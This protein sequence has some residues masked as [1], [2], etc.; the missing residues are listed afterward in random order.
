MRPMSDVRAVFA[1]RAEGHSRAAI[2]RLTGVSR[3]QVRFWLELGPEAVAASPMRAGGRTSAHAH[4]E[5]ELVTFVNGPAYAYLFGQYLGDGCLS[6]GPREVFRL[7]I[8]TCDAY[9]HLR[10][11]CERAIRVVMPGRVVGRVHRAGCTDVS[12]YSR[13]WPCLLP[14]HGA[15]RKH[16]RP[17]QLESW[18]QRLVLDSHPERFLR[19]LLHSDGCRV[20]N[21]VPHHLKLGVKEYSYPR[22]FFRNESEDILG[23]FEDACDRLGI[24]WRR[25]NWKTISVA[26]RMSVARLDSFVGPKH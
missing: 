18:Q 26:R 21:K 11:E 5:C 13:H 24:E 2:A 6:E 23:L 22:Y 19:G 3:T 14:Q 9:P 25:S 20:L 12:C 7:R 17:L 8:T 10:S 4:R 16:E 1:L 15:G